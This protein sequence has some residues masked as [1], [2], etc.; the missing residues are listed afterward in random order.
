[1]IA[2]PHFLA[3]FA[4]HHKEMNIKYIKFVDYYDVPVVNY[5]FTLLRKLIK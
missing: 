1:M 5:K 2:K 4:M 3:L